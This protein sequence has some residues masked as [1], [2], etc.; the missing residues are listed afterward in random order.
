[1]K[2]TLAIALLALSSR[3]A[4]AQPAS[5]GEKPKRQLPVEQP[6]N[7]YGGAPDDPYADP[8][9][10]PP[11]AKAPPAKAPAKAPPAKA[12]P[13]KAGKPGKPDDPYADPV[14][15]PPGA[16]ATPP[17]KT[18][19]PPPPKEITPTAIP[20]RVT[21][22]DLTAVQGLLAVQRLDGWLMFDR[23]GGNPI[24]ARLVSP[25]GHTSRPWFYLVPA[26]G[27]AIAL[28]HTAEVRSFDHLPGKK[29]TYQGY[30]DLAPQL[31]VLLKGM[32][33]VALEYSAKAAV[34]SV[35]R[36]DAGTLE[37][38]RGAG[39]A[40]RSSDTLVQ[41][42]KAIWGEAGRTAHYLAVHHMVELRKDAL[43]FIAKQVAGGAPITEYDVQQRLA[44]GLT[45]RGLVGIPPVVAAGVNTADPFYVPT[46]ARAAPIK[47]GDLITISIA[48]KADKPDGIWAAQTWMAVADATVSPEHAKAFETA[49]LG[50]DQALALIAERSRKKRPVTGAEVDDTVRA[51]FK[52]VKAVEK[53]MHRTGHSID[54]DFLGGG[55]DLDNFEVK[56]TRILTPG[57]GFT[58]GPGLYTAGQFG[59]RTEV[60]VYLAPAGPEI[61]TPAQDAIEALL[62]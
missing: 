6:V 58:V 52:K 8:P 20:A 40:V 19:K 39:V 46:A 15:A 43:A 17:E 2:R 54:N 24:A 26:K 18:G 51:F 32:R 21:L 30:R 36:V 31:K 37:L 45:M 25:G 61:T 10:T 33:T 35:S 47:R 55:A 60:S 16:P 28:V 53:V 42:T 13:A 56:D 23:D 27:D 22:Q 3:V 14:V 12:P 29:L 62:K 59:V 11:P 48:L 7:P 41:Y 50:R 44:R 49:A 34:P 57:T 38:I 5:E 4:V 1:M 9:P